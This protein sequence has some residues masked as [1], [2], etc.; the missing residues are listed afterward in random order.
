MATFS[1]LFDFPDLS[2]GQSELSS[3]PDSDESVASELS[4]DQEDAWYNMP[5]DSED[6]D[7]DSVAPSFTL[8][9]RPPPVTSTGARIK[10]IYMLEEK[11]SA[12]QIKDATG[13]SRSR[14]YALA[15][16]A[17]ERGWRENKNMP[18]EVSHVLNQPR[19]GRP[20][21]SADAIKCV[22]KIVLQNST[23]RGFSCATIAREVR[24]RGYEVAPRTVW[25]VLKAAG[26]SQCKLIVKPGLNKLNK[27]ERLDWCLA[28][29]HW[30]I[31][32]WKNVIFTDET[33]VQLGGTRGKRRVWRLPGEAY[34][35]HCIRR[36]W[37]GFSEFMFWGSFT[38]DKKGPCH[39]WEKE[40]PQEKRD[41]KANLDARNKKNEK[42]HK[43][44]WQKDYH[45]WVKEWTKAHGRRPGGQK[46]VWVH[47]EKTGAFVV[48][49]GRGGI[50]WYRY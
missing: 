44:K 24:N 6:E 45:K 38:Y 14:A 46:R 18:L 21:I 36:R 8:P 4:E 17:R 5:S 30:G 47:N 32:E 39:V 33:A 40:T 13:V 26:Y 2:D 7:D 1:G 31:E 34:N 11:K 42:A 12:D 10:A 48:K 15:A 23:T 28:H 29:E 9:I 16:V 3:P 22:L 43:A 49:N 37:K 35:K 20:A 50:N 27:K 19:S 25:K 41:R